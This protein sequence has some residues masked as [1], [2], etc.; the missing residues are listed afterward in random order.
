MKIAIAG[1][2]GFVGKALTGALVKNNHE[3]IILTRGSSKKNPDSGVRFVQW[4]SP[5]SDPLKDLENT[6]IFINLAGE[7]LSKGRWTEQRKK[8]ILD[9]RLNAVDELLAVFKKMNK[10]PGALINAS[11]I[12][13]Y[14]TSETE[15]FTETSQ[16]GH[17]F[18]AKTVTKWEQK[19]IEAEQ[20]GVRT[21][22]CRFGIILDRQEGAL[23]KI[24]FPY[25]AFVGGPIGSGRQWMSWIHIKDV[26]NALLF[27]IENRKIAGPV[28]FTA[29]HA[30]QMKEFARQLAKIL[31]RPHWLPV[32][33]IAL[34]LLL[35]EMSMLVLEG[36][37]VLP[38][39]LMEHGYSFQFPN[40]A[41]AV[42]DIFS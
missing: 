14:G 3:V 4:L 19:A 16:P 1:G 33:N 24:V 34:Q 42:R 37:K 7:S 9:S 30:V 2:S 17:D 11:A 13:Y 22:L 40:L 35:G 39:Q 23:P 36:Q 28:N 10:K 20:L 32:P 27:V 38:N 12:G 6:E 15:I 18:L 5:A 8:Q 29:P 26:V 41:D 21:V 25:Q 31:H